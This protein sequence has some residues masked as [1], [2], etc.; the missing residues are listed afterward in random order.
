M[1]GP[2]FRGERDAD[3]HVVSGIS[4]ARG[5]P[6]GDESNSERREIDVICKE[7]SCDRRAHSRGW[8]TTHYRRYRTGKRMDAP[9]RRYVPDTLGELVAAPPKNIRRKRDRPF[10]A[11]YALL[12]ELG[13]YDD[14]GHR[15]ASQN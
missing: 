1:N 11:E 10:A 14:H 7:E 15:I 2:N 5:Y 13:V 4:V 6:P 3:S 8:C 9:I 12:A